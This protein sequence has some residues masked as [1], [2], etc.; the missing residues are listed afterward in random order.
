MMNA[1][2]RDVVTAIK[3]DHRTLERMFEQLSK[4]PDERLLAQMSTLFLAHGKAE[5]AQVYPKLAQE[6][7]EDKDEVFHGVKE[8]REAEKLLRDLQGEKPGTKA[9]EQALKKFVESV[10]HHV[11][12][13]ESDLLPKLEEELTATESQRLAEA[14]HKAEEAETQ[15][16]EATSGRDLDVML[17]EELLAQAELMGVEGAAGKSKDE[18]K[19]ELHRVLHPGLGRD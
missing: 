19:T 15:R 3:D 17:K 14:F 8:H 9:F 2:E 5:E 1:G 4:N 18:L 11:E 13:E 12:E 7:P 10:D 6:A 16:L